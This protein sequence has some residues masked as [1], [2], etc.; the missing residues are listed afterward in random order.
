MRLSTSTAAMHIGIARFYRYRQQSSGHSRRGSHRPPLIDPA[1]HLFHTFDPPRVQTSSSNIQPRP[2]A[3]TG[4]L[5]QSAK[6]GDNEAPSAG[7]VRQCR[8]GDATR[9]GMG[10]IRIRTFGIGTAD[11]SGR[12][13]RARFEGGDGGQWLARR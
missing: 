11:W 10:G 4:P 8:P 6:Y 2:W 12:P 1:V 5:S 3:S 13:S 9:G 7:V